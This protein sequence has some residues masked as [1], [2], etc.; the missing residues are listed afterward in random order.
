[1]E[2]CRLLTDEINSL[3]NDLFKNEQPTY[4]LYIHTQ[5][6]NFVVH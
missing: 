4:G 3:W 1:L 5:N 6:V 2:N